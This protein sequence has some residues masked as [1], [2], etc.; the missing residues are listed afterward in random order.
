MGNS[1]NEGVRLHR[2]PSLLVSFEHHFGAA[3]FA[4]PLLSEWPCIRRDAARR[5]QAG[6]VESATP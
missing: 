4:A 5:S 2:E 6:F 1:M 3:A